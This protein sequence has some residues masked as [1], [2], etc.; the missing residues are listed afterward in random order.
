MV[1]ERL[2]LV[3][4]V[5]Q[6]DSCLDLVTIRTL[7]F[8]RTVWIKISAIQMRCADHERAREDY[9]T[10]NSVHVSRYAF[11][12]PMAFICRSQNHFESRS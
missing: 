9:T 7:T 8:S 5:K 6:E 12:M 3:D 1:V 4:A 2:V 11:T 10:G